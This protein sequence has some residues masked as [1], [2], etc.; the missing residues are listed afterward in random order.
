M[1]SSHLGGLSPELILRIL[2]FMRPSEYSGFARTCRLG[3][4]LVNI[5]L[6]TPEDRLSSLPGLR[7]NGTHF[8]LEARRLSWNPDLILP[9]S[10]WWEEDFRGC[11]GPDPDENDSDL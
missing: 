10:E 11:Y 2:D 3:R 8:F 4:S 7:R 5:K 9:A 6:N 1:D